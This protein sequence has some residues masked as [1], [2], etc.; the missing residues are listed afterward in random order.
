MSLLFSFFF[1]VVLDLKLFIALCGKYRKLIAE[2]QNIKIVIN[3][4]QY[5]I[6]FIYQSVL[7]KQWATKITLKMWNKPPLQHFLIP[8]I[9]YV[10]ANLTFSSVYCRNQKL[11]T[12]LFS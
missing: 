10:I 7:P 5:Q 8:T 11:N 3:D 9:S 12:K 1:F 6:F 4:G 2:I